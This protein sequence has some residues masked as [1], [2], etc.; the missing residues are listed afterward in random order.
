M[1]DEYERFGGR[2]CLEGSPPL[3]PQHFRVFSRSRES[4]GA[5]RARGAGATAAAR[6][7]YYYT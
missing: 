2:M 5:L 3:W 4:L 6:F 7:I 1:V